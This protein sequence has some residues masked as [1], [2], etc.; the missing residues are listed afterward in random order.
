MGKERDKFWLDLY[1]INSHK[2][3]ERRHLVLTHTDVME[4]LRM[5]SSRYYTGLSGM[6]SYQSDMYVDHSRYKTNSRSMV[7]VAID[8]MMHI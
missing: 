1:L 3:W 4:G 2:A 5:M 8:N 6:L 7:N